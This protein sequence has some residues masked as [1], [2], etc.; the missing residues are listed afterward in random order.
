MAE[1]EICLLLNQQ[2]YPEAEQAARSMT[3]ALPDSGFGWKA[4]G[5][6]LHHQA[7][8]AEAIAS[9]QEA[10]RLLPGDAEAHAN[11]G[12]AHNA[13]GL[14]DEAQAHFECALA[15]APTCAPFLVDIGALCLRRGQLPLAM[16]HLRRALELRL[17]QTS[18]QAEPVVRPAFDT[19]AHEALLW[20]TLAELAH[21]GV[22]AFAHAGTLLGLEREGRLLPFDKDLDLGLPYAER[23]V[24]HACLL[25]SGW[26]EDIPIFGLINPRSYQH[27]E[28]GL[29][30]DLC[31]FRVE[32]STGKTISGFWLDQI[33]QHWNRITEYPTLNL[34]RQKRPSGW[35]WALAE[36]HPWLQALYNDW[37]TPDPDFDTTISAY[38]Q[39]GFS[40]LTQCFA[41]LR[42]FYHWHRGDLKK[43]LATTRHSL[44]Q[45][46][47]D[48]LLQQ[49]HLH[50]Q[51]AMQPTP[52][53]IA[54]P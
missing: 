25:A 52:K 19:P 28:T 44:R 1:S 43:A 2:R 8:S 41:L 18:Q 16:T 24:A 3:V 50:L 54:E 27:I 22:H 49:V 14:L 4:L 51:A 45:L 21:A 48:T 11:L 33:P 5:A 39:R 31:F 26:K 7:R 9:M 36:P 20:Q 29:A 35:V 37:R 30:L 34:V 32:E 13:C 40:L 15:L 46:P 42:I 6:V 17:Y 12:H 38:N 47:D 53:A 10:V 23:G